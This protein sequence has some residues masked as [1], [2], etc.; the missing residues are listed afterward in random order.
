MPP[1]SKKT[2]KAPAPTSIRIIAGQWR[3][4]KLPVLDETGLRPTG[5]RVRETLFNWLMA[6]INGARCLDLF[7]GSGALGLEALSR[8]AAEVTFVELNSRAA[9]Q[10]EINLR[11]LNCQQARVRTTDALRFL[12]SEDGNRFDL[13]FVDPPFDNNLWDAVLQKIHHSP[14]LG[15]SALV[16]VESPRKSSLSLPPGWTTKREKT[17]GDV[18]FGLYQ[19][20]QIDTEDTW[21][22][23]Q[24]Q[25]AVPVS[26][27]PDNGSP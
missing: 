1:R 16:Y 18:R 15:N 9:R 4:R 27:L 19:P 25:S 13:V 22:H 14:L 24:Q 8:G 5:D 10:L 20:A 7:A 21:E 3:S 26:V 11:T 17:A 12:D 2:Q 6:D 23:D